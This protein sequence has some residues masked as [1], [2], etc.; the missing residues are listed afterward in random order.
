MFLSVLY[1]L[2]LLRK[3]LR[4]STR[5]S[6]RLLAAVCSFQSRTQP[7]RDRQTFAAVFCGLL[8][9]I[10]YIF[11]GQKSRF[12]Y[13]SRP[14]LYVAPIFCIRFCAF[15]ICLFLVY[16]T[17]KQLI[18]RHGY[19][20]YFQHCGGSVLLALTCF[21][22]PDGRLLPLRTKIRL[23]FCHQGAASKA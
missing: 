21:F 12:G 3:L 2:R 22:S 11:G 6:E 20:H 4:I 8:P 1:N 14:F 17:E 7:V 10:G 16:L 18:F 5:N 9:I 23:L 15:R 19:I 13:F